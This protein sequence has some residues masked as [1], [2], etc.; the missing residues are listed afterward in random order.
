MVADVTETKRWRDVV[1]LTKPSVTRMCVLTTA[2][3]YLLAPGERDLVTGLGAVVGVALAVAGASAF[4]MWIERDSDALMARTRRRP[5]PAGRLAPSVALT[6]ASL[7]SAASVVVL[8]ATTNLLTTA[9]STL[10]ILL[11]AAVYTPLKFRTPLS[12]VIGAV[13]GAV[14]PML[15]W[16]AHT[17][18]LD[19]VAWVLFGIL[20]AWQIPHFIAIALYRRDEYARAGIRTVPLTRGDAVAKIQAVI[21]A[22]LLVPISLMLGPLGVSG[23][24]YLLCASVLGAIFMGWSFTGLDNAAGP[25]WARGFFV[26]SLLYLPALTLALVLDANL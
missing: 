7:A 19:T 24:V 8:L 25:R 3:G 6:V 10:A 14:P 16:T 26:A 1:E 5:L 4:N 17:G 15:G 18:R 21:W 12:L 2:G 13:P 20:L 22:S 23:S 9:V 11:Y